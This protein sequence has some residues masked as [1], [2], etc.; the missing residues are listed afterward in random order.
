VLVV[1]LLMA[2]SSPISWPISKLLDWILGE[3]RLVSHN[4]ML[5]IFQ[6]LW[7]LHGVCTYGVKSAVASCPLLYSTSRVRS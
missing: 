7:V 6:L 4:V 2:L 5:L 1:P 3:E